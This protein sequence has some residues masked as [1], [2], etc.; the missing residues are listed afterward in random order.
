M[1]ADRYELLVFDL[2]GTLADTSDDL[3][4]SINHALETV[5]RDPL[6]LADV[7]R[8]VGNGARVLIERALGDEGTESARIE[9]VLERFLEHYESNCLVETQLYPGVTRTLR[10]LGKKQLAVLTNKPLLPCRRILSGL[11]I[12]E[13]FQRVEGGDSA[14]ARKPDPRGLLCLLEALGVS[15]EH[16]LL[17]GDTDVDVETARRGGTHVAGVTYGF[18]P[19]DFAEHPPDYLLDS[20]DELLR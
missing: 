8:Y 14:P 11:G 1:L 2:D 4:R 15:P 20:L 18:R 5:G 12:L 19:G 13:L 17:L 3:A 6:P 7:L 16:T 9:A 10:A